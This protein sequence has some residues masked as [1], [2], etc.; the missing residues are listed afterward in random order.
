M[1]AE[2]TAKTRPLRVL[3]L[4]PHFYWPQLA[5]T[6][7]PVKF[8][9]IGGM[10]SQIYRL[11]GELD[12]HDVEQ[13]V[14][15]LRIPGAPKSWAMSDRTVVHGVRVPI[16]PIRSRIR[17]M[18]DL[19]L[20]WALGVLAHLVRHRTRP[21]VLH[22]HCSGVIIPPL[23]GWLLCRVLRVPLVLTVHCSIIV[24]YHPMNALDRLLQ[25][26]ARWI[27]R[28][29]VK[30]A[31][32]TV[33]LTPRTVPILAKDAGVPEDR[34]TV[35]PDVIDADAFAARATPGTVAEA[36]RRWR[37]PEGTPVVGYVGRIAREK[38]WPILLDIAEELRDTDVHLLICGDG[39]ERDL[40]EQEVRG[41]GL[42][43]RVTVTGYLPNEDIPIAM[44]TMDL[45]LMAPLHE[46][47]G[48]VMLEA[49]ACELPIIA[50]G[51]GGV[52]DV[53]EQGALGWLVPER[54]AEAF[55][56]GIRR[57]LADSEWRATTAER[58][59]KTVRARYALSQVTTA[60]AEVYR[61]IVRR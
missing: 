12:A 46:E 44:G 1:N 17:G 15:T 41:R 60:T 13:T 40:F 21:D 20:A 11:T 38:G 37:L 49:M 42:A 32:C 43:E 33:T 3:R 54:T 48:S 51:V 24:T 26:L 19:N 50:V 47:F 35:L 61:S 14:L 59:A 36:A 45:L 7:W 31:A 25:P 27:E 22:V 34:I 57:A 56:D 55:A 2:P 23:I 53:L 9:A 5:A 29:A 8:D 16:L 39:N 30:A 52:A 10:Q 6:S 58:A 4:S 28:R 18:V